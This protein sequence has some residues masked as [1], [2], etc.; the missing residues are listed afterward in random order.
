[1]A[2]EQAAAALAVAALAGLASGLSGFGAGIVM[3]AY[4][5]PLLGAKATIP[6]LAVAMIVTNAGRLWAF[7]ADV[8]LA[9]AG[10]VLMGAIPGAGLGALLLADL[11]D[12][13]ADLILGLFLIASIPLRR[14]M[15][16][17][18]A[19]LPAAGLVAGGFA[20][21]AASGVT[22]GAG[23]LILPLLLGAGLAGPALLGTDTVVSLVLNLGRALAFGGVD[24]LGLELAGLGLALGIATIPGSHA[25]A[26]VVR[27][28][29][30]RLHTLLLEVLVALAGL[31]VAVTAG[32]S[33]WGG[34]S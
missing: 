11:S 7:R 4:L 32:W 25:A 3:S 8:R 18:Q 28:T 31:H 29:S 16:G 1:M 30:L 14:V 5:A 2:V 12:P 17:R 21:G 26:W 19:V 22:T 6:V 10:R 15:A 34:P 24:L 27:R 9:L 33:L 20:I 13:I 23:T